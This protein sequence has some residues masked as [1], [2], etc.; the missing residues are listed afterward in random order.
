MDRCHNRSSYHGEQLIYSSQFH[1]H[2]I[3][4]AMQ[5]RSIQVDFLRLFNDA[6]S[7][8]ACIASDE[9]ITEC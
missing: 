8:E 5:T 1:V 4:T 2:Y 3:I 7:I 6:L 9:V